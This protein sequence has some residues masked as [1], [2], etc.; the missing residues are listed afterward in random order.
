MHQI[1]RLSEYCDDNLG[2]ACTDE[3]LFLGRTALIERHCARLTVR[4]RTEIERLLSRAYEEDLMA[5]RLLP[6]LAMVAA[7]LNGNDPGLARIAAVHLRIPDLPDQA[8]RDRLEAEEILIKSI[9]RESAPLALEVAPLNTGGIVD[10]NES[11]LLS[12]TN[13]IRKASPNDPKHPGWPA[14]TEGGR[15]GQF[16]PKDASELGQNV[17]A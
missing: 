14:G 4:E 17:K 16:R 9:D 13:R 6:G 5:D 11:F 12:P 8:A 15:G 2:L 3:G 7:A 10:F 1:W